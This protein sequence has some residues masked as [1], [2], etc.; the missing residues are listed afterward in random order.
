MFPE[1]G[2]Y[3][4]VD[5]TGELLALTDD[6]DELL[7]VWMP[8]ARAYFA[9]AASCGYPGAAGWAA[10]REPLTVRIVSTETRDEL[11]EDGTPLLQR[12]P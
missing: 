1:F 9:E 6:R 4:L 10:R 7:D 8:R 11:L 5:A 12:E 3:V 2:G